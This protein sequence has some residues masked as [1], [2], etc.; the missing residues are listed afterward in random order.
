M[1]IHEK[2]ELRRRV[3]QQQKDEAWD[4]KAK[5]LIKE[6]HETHS[7][8]KLQALEQMGYPIDW[9]INNHN[10]PSWAK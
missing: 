6:W 7:D 5:R 3:L 2:M 10:D 4:L 9:D 8:M 1:D